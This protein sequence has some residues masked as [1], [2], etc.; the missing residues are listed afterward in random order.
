MDGTYLWSY[1]VTMY[2][3]QKSGSSCP[4]IFANLKVLTDLQISLVEIQVTFG[5][6]VHAKGDVFNVP[7]ILNPTFPLHWPDRCIC[8]KNILK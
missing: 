5:R 6:T 7:L 3:Q 2:L 4:K 1:S 8:P